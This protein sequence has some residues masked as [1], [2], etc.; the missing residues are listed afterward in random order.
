LCGSSFVLNATKN[1][2][3]L[4]SPGYPQ[5]YGQNIRCRYVATGSGPYDRVDIRFE[6]IQI[7]SSQDCSKDRLRIRD[8]SSSVSPSKFLSSCIE[9]FKSFST[10]SF[11]ITLFSPY[12]HQHG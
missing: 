6:D 11:P 8:V 10:L 7:E 2:Q 9:L 3:Q 4:T 5:N 1:S 12:F